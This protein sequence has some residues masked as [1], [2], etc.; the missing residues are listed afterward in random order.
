M[1]INY[2]EM[3]ANA[4][5]CNGALLNFHSDGILS[6][7]AKDMVAASTSP[8]ASILLPGFI[9]LFTSIGRTNFTLLLA[10]YSNYFEMLNTT[11]QNDQD[12]G[13]CLVGLESFAILAQ[14]P[15]AKKLFAC[16]KI[17]NFNAEQCLKQLKK[18]LF[19]GG[20]DDVHVQFKTHC[21]PPCIN[22]F[23]FSVQG[24]FDHS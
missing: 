14:L 7:I 3:M 2:L 13:A 22:L 1:L 18:I 19:R 20:S 8:M 23:I 4:V 15:E 5:I 9:K 10:S 24:N 11:C 16:E 21:Q 12:I 6:N 17:P